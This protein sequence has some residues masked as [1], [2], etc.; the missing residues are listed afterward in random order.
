V[1]NTRK[2]TITAAAAAAAATAT[3][4]TVA[5][6]AASGSPQVH[7]GIPVNGPVSVN[8]EVIGGGADSFTGLQTPQYAMSNVHGVLRL[9]LFNGTATPSQQFKELHTV[10]DTRLAFE[11]VGTNKVMTV[12]RF[13]GLQLTRLSA[14]GASARQ[15]WT[16]ASPGLD[17][18]L[19]PWSFRNV[20]TG[21]YL[22]PT[23]FGHFIT[24]G[25][26]PVGWVEH[27]P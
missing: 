4:G 18:N 19:G 23:N 20:G 9:T 10:A 12:T 27:T 17:P 24:V 22:V 1:S 13:H 11:A 16:W 25:V 21:Q 2:I 7:A 26:N 6:S 14:G 5:A 3:L 8:T 15:L